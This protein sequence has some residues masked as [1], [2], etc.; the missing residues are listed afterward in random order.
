MSGLKVGDSAPDL[1]LPDQDGKEI[2]LS[3]Y[4]SKG[5]LVVFFCE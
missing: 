4:W 5:P 2:K 1:T 3:E